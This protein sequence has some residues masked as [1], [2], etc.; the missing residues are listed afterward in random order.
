MQRTARGPTEHALAEQERSIEVCL[1]RLVLHFPR[2]SPREAGSVRLV[3]A[4]AR[5]R[6]ALPDLSLA[7]ATV[8]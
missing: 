8:G 1:A 3:L 5:V 7:V 4:F 6:Q 2:P